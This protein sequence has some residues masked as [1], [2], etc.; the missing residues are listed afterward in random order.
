MTF[1]FNN[2]F[3]SIIKSELGKKYLSSGKK[4]SGSIKDDK[5][6]LYIEDDYGKHSAFMSHYFY[7]KIIDNTING[8]FRPATYVLFLLGL[9]LGVAVESVIAALVLQNLEGLFMPSVIIV[10]EIVYFFA[11][12]R[13][14]YENN[15]LIEDY[16]NKISDE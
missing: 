10:A 16:L 1:K 12:N 15:K 2:S 14:S 7:G 9:L 3:I 13:M 5:I 6:E 8:R 4:I 11:L